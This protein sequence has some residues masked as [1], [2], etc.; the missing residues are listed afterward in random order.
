MDSSSESDLK[1]FPLS[2]LHFLV[3]VLLLLLLPSTFSYQS[4]NL[5]M[6]SSLDLVPLVSDLSK[7]YSSTQSVL[8]SAPRWDSLAT[9]FYNQFGNKPDFVAR[10]PGRVNIIGESVSKTCSFNHFITH[11]LTLILSILIGPTST[12]YLSFPYPLTHSLPL[13]HSDTSIIKA[14]LFCQLR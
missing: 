1:I 13:T 11:E 14:S 6:T 3:L 8:S 2:S 12:F 7:I 5:I 10:A 9:N 4:N